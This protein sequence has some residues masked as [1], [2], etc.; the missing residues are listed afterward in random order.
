[1][2][3]HSKR[4]GLQQCLKQMFVY[5]NDDTDMSVLGFDKK[6]AGKGYTA[7]L[8]TERRNGITPS[9]HADVYLVYYQS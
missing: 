3:F 2:I 1:M 5:F 4:L 9:S 8:E 6:K 7:I